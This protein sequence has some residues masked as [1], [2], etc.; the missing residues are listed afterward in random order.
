MRPWEV[1]QLKYSTDTQVAEKSGLELDR[2]IQNPLV[3]EI[4]AILDQIKSFKERAKVFYFEVVLSAVRCPSCSGRLHM[5]GQSEC[6]C[7]CGNVLD[8]TVEFQKSSC[9]GA[10][11]VRKTFHYSCL[12][13]H[14]VVPSRFLFDEKLFDGEYFRVMMRESR[15]RS[16]RKKEEI[17]RLLVESRSGAL[18][19]LED[20]NLE[21]IPGLL[22]DLDGF[23]ND[24]LNAI[25][26]FHFD[27]ETPFEM[28]KYRE[29]ILSNLG[30]NSTQFTDIDPFIDDY[31]KDRV[32]RFVTLVFMQHDREVDIEQNGNELLIQRHYHE[33]HA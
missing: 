26:G 2:F 22:D 29:H 7:S 24:G 14:R 32:W 6:A 4:K 30:W 25:G 3:R 11:L 15:R 16:Q 13:C 18:P 12:K 21:S 1:A 10:K 5:T 8:P 31:R 20:P 28:D 17:R 23:I 27:L 33:A 9:C 19:L